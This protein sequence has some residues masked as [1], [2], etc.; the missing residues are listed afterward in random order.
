MSD[1]DQPLARF[2]AI[3][4]EVARAWEH[5]L[6]ADE[7]NEVQD[8][9]PSTTMTMAA[10][11]IAARFGPGRRYRENHNMVVSIIPGP[12]K[13]MY[14]CGARLIAFTGM[15][16]ILDNLALSHTVTTYDGKL[17]IAPICDR[18]I[19]PDPAFYIECLQA[20]F[21]ELRATV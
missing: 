14:L 5:S 19:M 17:T 7:I 21:E 12:E 4:R 11:T 16:I 8:V 20:S 9:L 10:K 15:A 13:P 2:K 3:V 6:S 1:I 18:K